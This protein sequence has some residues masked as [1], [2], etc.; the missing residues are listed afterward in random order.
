MR[1]LFLLPACLLFLLTSTAEAEPAPWYWWVSK[2]DGRRVCLQFSPG[3]GWAPSRGPYRDS[4]CTQPA[5]H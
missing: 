2:V 4:R 1:R 5:T 3:E